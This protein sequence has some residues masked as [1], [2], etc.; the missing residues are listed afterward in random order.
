MK[1]PTVYVDDS[2][3]VLEGIPHTL[4]GGISF[5]DEQ[6]ALL[7]V[8]EIKQ[9]LG[10]SPQH[11][12]KWN[13]KSFSQEQRHFITEHMLPVLSK[14]QGFLIISEH[15]KH[16]AAL[17]LA[18]Q[19]SDF[20]QDKQ[21]SGFVFRFDNNI[22]QNSTEFDRHAYSL[23]PPCVGWNN[24][25]SAH[26]Q[27]M[28]CADLFVGFHKLRMDFGLERVDR[29]KMIELDAYNDG[30]RGEFELEWYVRLSLRHSLWGHLEGPLDE[31]KFKKNLG[32]GVRVFSKVSKATMEKAL[33]YL[34]HDY[35][36]CIY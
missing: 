8:L 25:D 31:T 18:T 21:L 2:S 10:I 13:S 9:R 24:I 1:I 15:G 5:N 27:L 11:E 32:F 20:C 6:E 4:L 16:T 7:A 23:Q 14:T 12:I 22:I 26:D 28:Q 17:E 33:T 35:L 34:D 36:G 30:V 19:L 3:Y 29:N